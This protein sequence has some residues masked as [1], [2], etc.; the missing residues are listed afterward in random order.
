[1]KAL[2]ILG[3]TGSIGTQTLDL[4]AQYPERFRVVG[5]ASRSQVA[6]L[7]EQIR[8]FRPEI[9]GLVQEQKLAELQTLISDLDPQPRLVVGK[10]GL[11]EVAAYGAAELVV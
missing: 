5:L 1:M 4:V 2:T 11:C 3:S 8:Q 6:L 7:A 10:E 9:V